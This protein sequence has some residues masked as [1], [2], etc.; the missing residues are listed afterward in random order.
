MTSKELTDVVL[1]W[2]SLTILL[3]FAQI[4]TYFVLGYE[5]G[6]SILLYMST[7]PLFISYWLVSLEI[8]KSE[9]EWLIAPK[10]KRAYLVQRDSSGR[11]KSRT[12]G[13]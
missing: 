11:F 3:A 6:I 1:T 8:K 4:I 10:N 7:L 12:N 2:S 5:N 13:Q 9:T